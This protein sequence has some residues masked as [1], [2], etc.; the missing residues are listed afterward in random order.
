MVE[1]EAEIF[2][3]TREV[4]EIN[5]TL[6]RVNKQLESQNEKLRES[7]ERFASFMLH[8]P[9]AAWIKD[10]EG[11]YVYAN[12]EAERIFSMPL[13]A[14]LGKIDQDV[15]PEE[16]A[17]MFS[18]N[19]SRV[20]SEGE[21][22]QMTEVLRQ[23]DGVEHHSI[24]NKFVVRA[25]DG[26]PG[27]V[28]GCA[29]DITERI[30]AEEEINKLNLSLTKRTEE[31]ESANKELEAFNRTVAHDLRQPLNVL[32]TYCQVIQMLGGEQL[33]GEC[34]EYVQKAYKVTLRMNG[35]I[36]ALLNFSRIGHVELRREQFDLGQLAHE[37]AR[38]LKQTDPKRQVEFR[39]P[40]R[41]PVQA[42]ASLLRL[43]LDNLIGNAWKYTDRREK[44]IIELGVTD[45][46]GVPAYFVRDNGSG[47]DGACA[48][49]LFIPF[50]RLSGAD[51]H[52]GFGV[53]LATVE[54]IIRRHGGKVWAEGKPDRGATFY[55][56]LSA[57]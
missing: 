25:A 17:R 9:V 18:E 11:R 16:T 3:K 43:V 57:S 13:D 23:A 1:M 53:G 34:S 6:K 36:E 19:D 50:Q 15:F 38:E 47:F 26:K 8:M 44:A 48:E 40:E 39:I 4:A 55:F 45:I 24:V 31:L 52:K 28:A 5:Q 32:S 46:E 41:M 30:R 54:S 22:L 56:T 20:L 33:R 27:F 21:K 42:D 2:A 49:N 37:V 10:M 29:L 35:I 51:G 14:L 7:E 12:A